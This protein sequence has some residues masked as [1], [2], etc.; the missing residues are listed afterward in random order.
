MVFF[1]LLAVV[2][3]VVADQVTKML[4]VNLIKPEQNITVIDNLLSFTYLENRGAAFGIL[5]NQRFVFIILTVL[6]MLV[7]LYVLLRYDIKS[8]FFYCSLILIVSGGIGNLIDR[9]FLGYVV[10]FI[11]VSFFPPVFN[12][13]DCCVTVGAVMLPIAILFFKDPIA[14]KSKN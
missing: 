3:L 6:I 7:F 13:A 5:Q 14:K 1:A 4:A 10:D 9:L 2:L 12:F 11:W 8:K